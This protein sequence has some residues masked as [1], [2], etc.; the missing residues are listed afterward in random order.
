MNKQDEIKTDMEKMAKNAKRLLMRDGRL[1]PVIMFFRK[2]DPVGGSPLL[3]DSED[4]KET[5]MLI[6]G[7][8][9]HFMRVDRVILI[10]DAI[11]R[12]ERSSLKTGEVKKVVKR[13]AINVAAKSN[14]G[15]LAMMSIPY[16]RNPDGEIV[17]SDPIRIDNTGK[18][19]IEIPI[20]DAVFPIP[21][22]ANGSIH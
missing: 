11:M 17:F 16:L 22:P 9:V 8:I 6:V 1:T 2:G 21:D 5:S 18:G 4:G 7:Q 13:E 3:F 19:D 20:L 14:D 12:E 15:Y 10:Y